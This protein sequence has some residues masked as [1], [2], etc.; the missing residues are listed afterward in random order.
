[1]PKFAKSG[2]EGL[3][4]KYSSNHITLLW[5]QRSICFMVLGGMDALGLK[6]DNPVIMTANVLT[7]TCR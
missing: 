3:S 6:C 1:M 7:V 4:V 2:G 5:H